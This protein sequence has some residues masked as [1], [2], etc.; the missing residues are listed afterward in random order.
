MKKILSFD[1][2]EIS[3]AYCILLT[4]NGSYNIID[5]QLNSIRTKSKNTVNEKIENL[6]ELLKH[7]FK[8][9]NDIDYV[10]IE[11]QGD[12]RPFMKS[13][14]MVIYTY[15]RLQNKDV[16]IRHAID[17]FKSD[18][19]DDKI[20]S[21]ITLTKS[22]YQNNKNLSVAYINSIIPKVY[23]DKFIIHKDCIDDYSDALFQAIEF[24]HKHKNMMC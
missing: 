13:L 9:D 5:W 6:I 11:H 22:K 7:N 10:L 3:L 23:M 24:I 18:I 12:F 17:K 16:K 8:S 14:Q 20:K 15:F 21:T 4:D 1:I 2:G 19:I